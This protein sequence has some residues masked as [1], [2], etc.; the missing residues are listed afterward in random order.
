MYTYVTI[1]IEEEEVMN[2]RGSKRRHGSVG[3]SLDG[4]RMLQG[5]GMVIRKVR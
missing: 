2:L 5:K 4:A 3:A 1:I